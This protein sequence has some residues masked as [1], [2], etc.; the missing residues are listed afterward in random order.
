MKRPSKQLQAAFEAAIAA[1]GEE[2]VCA[3][4][5]GEFADIRQSG[6]SESAILRA[7]REYSPG[8]RPVPKRESLIFKVI[9]TARLN[10][11]VILRLVSRVRTVVR[12][13]IDQN[14]ADATM[15]YF[16]EE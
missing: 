12:Q 4:L 10:H 2:A 7:I 3:K 13:E 8:P 14:Y 16:I 1:H 15:V 11:N 6:I 5:C 9:D